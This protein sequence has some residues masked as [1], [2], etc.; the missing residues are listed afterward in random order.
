MAHFFLRWF[1]VPDCVM[2]KI[3]LRMNILYFEPCVV[4]YAKDAILYNH[5]SSIYNEKNRKNL[6]WLRLHLSTYYELTTYL[7]ILK[8]ITCSNRRLSTKK[9]TLRSWKRFFNQ[10]YRVL[11]KRVIGHVVL[12]HFVERSA[13][14]TISKCFANSRRLAGTK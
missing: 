4:A 8:V 3:A 10:L 11:D 7:T 6:I 13:L 12:V 2:S 14:K 5:I 9:S 1:K